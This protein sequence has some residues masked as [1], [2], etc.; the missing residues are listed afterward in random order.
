M[1]ALFS[2]NLQ[3]MVLHGKTNQLGTQ[4][5]G[6]ALDEIILLG[7]FR[8]GCGVRLVSG[9]INQMTKHIKRQPEN[10]DFGKKE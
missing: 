10:K 9:L 1:I 2:V 3:V 6:Q 8:L 5:M 4:L 7:R